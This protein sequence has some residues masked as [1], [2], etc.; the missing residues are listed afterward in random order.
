MI[1]ERIGR[2]YT[3]LDVETTG[4]SSARGDRVIELAMVH[5][6]DGHEEDTFHRWFMPDRESSDG[7]LRVHGMDTAALMERSGGAPFAAAIPEIVQFVTARRQGDALPW[8]VIHNA[9]FDIG[10]VDAEFA[11]AGGA[12]TRF[13]PLVRVFDTFEYY[14]AMGRPSRGLDALL[15]AHGIARRH[16]E[17]S[18]LD[19][20]RLLSRLVEADAHAR[21]P[22]A[23]RRSS[24]NRR[25][26]G[27]EALVPDPMLQERR[28]RATWAPPAR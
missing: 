20:A 3:T 15:V 1:L 28:P 8:I 19:D 16:D 14:R 6:R 24:S 10:F 12:A 25:N 5:V 7:A 23:V 9:E 26:A 4:L 11:R 21:T 17:H 2:T 22:H 13:G 27:L 18:A